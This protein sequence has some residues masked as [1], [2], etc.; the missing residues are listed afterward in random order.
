MN[1]Q[2]L[3]VDELADAAEGLLDRIRGHRR[4]TMI[5]TYAPRLTYGLTPSPREDAQHRQGSDR[6]VDSDKRRILERCLSD[7]ET[8]KRIAM[9]P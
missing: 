7:Q 4:E 9:G 1:R 3:S 5:M 2:H 6:L 8:I